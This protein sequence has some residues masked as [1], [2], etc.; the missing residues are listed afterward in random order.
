MKAL[1][2]SQMSTQIPKPQSSAALCHSHT[3]LYQPHVL[4]SLLIGPCSAVRGMMCSAA[5][6]KQKPDSLVIFCQEVERHNI[7]L[8]QQ[9]CRQDVVVDTSSSNQGLPCCCSAVARFANIHAH[10]CMCCHDH[11]CSHMVPVLPERLQK[12]GVANIC[13]CTRLLDASSAP[14]EHSYS[15]STLR[16]LQTNG[17]IHKSLRKLWTSWAVFRVCPNR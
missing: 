2:S 8:E 1:R 15:E 12:W 13:E 16:S 10:A 7:R 17:H 14:S 6:V 4:H 11:T 5:Q 9:I 3:Q